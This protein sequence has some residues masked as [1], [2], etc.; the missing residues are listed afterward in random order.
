MTFPS[1]L[2]F[3]NNFIVLPFSQTQTSSPQHTSS[4][5]SHCP[6]SPEPPSLPGWLI[7]PL[8]NVSQCECFCS[9]LPVPRD[10]QQWLQDTGGGYQDVI[11]RRHHE[12]HEV[13]A[14]EAQGRAAEAV[15]GRSAQGQCLR[16]SSWPPHHPF[17]QLQ[18][19]P[20]DS[21]HRRVQT[22]VSL[23]SRSTWLS[24]GAPLSV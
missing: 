22:K 19:A 20:T 10:L 16:R 15:R 11:L 2:A 13:R 4:P 24:R 1:D 9:K 23:I 12:R 17:W 7:D 6:S 21:H 8:L 18:P 5:A 14:R 3:V